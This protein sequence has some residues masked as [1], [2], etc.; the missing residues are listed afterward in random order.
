MRFILMPLLAAMAATLVMASE[1]PLPA[2]GASVWTGSAYLHQFRAGCCLEI[3]GSL[4]GVLR[5]RTPM[6]RENVY[7]YT[8]QWQDAL[9]QAVHHSGHT[10]KGLMLDPDTAEFTVLTKNNRSLTVQARRMADA[11]PDD[12]CGPPPW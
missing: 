6:G 2:M 5:I 1:L 7:H 8:G 12:E 3:D 11:L 9:F 4:R 10:A